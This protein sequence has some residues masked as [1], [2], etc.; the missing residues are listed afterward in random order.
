MISVR[1]EECGEIRY[2]KIRL[3]VGVRGDKMGWDDGF[4]G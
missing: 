3:D 1:G 4:S 2:D